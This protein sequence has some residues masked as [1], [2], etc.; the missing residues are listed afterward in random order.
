[1]SSQGKCTGCYRVHPPRTV[2][3]TSPFQSVI[4]KNIRPDVSEAAAIRNFVREIEA[5]QISLDKLFC[6]AAEL[7]RCSQQYRAFIP[8]IWRIPPELLAEIFI[9]SI[10]LEAPT[11]D[12]DSYYHIHHH[13]PSAQGPLISGEICQEWR[14]IALLAPRLWNSMF[15]KC[16]PSNMQASILLCETWIGVASVVNTFSSR[17]QLQPSSDA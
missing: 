13:S 10:D 16:T 1:M 4:T 6:E 14:A 15:L 11:S 5:A 9:H 12:S 2:A 17:T 7:R 8:P 3:I